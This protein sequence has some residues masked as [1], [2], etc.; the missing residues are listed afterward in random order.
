MAEAV[1]ARLDAHFATDPAVNRAP[2]L[3]A[4]AV[5]DVRIAIYDDLRA[6]ERDW[7]AIEPQAD[8][9][10]FQCFDWLAAWQ[11]TIGVREGVPSRKRACSR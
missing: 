1:P 4:A 5:S 6:I 2:A 3:P 8:G 10:V 7:R 9:T 11:R